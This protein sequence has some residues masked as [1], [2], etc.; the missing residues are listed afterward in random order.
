LDAVDT[1]WQV[2]HGLR[3]AR[4]GIERMLRWRLHAPPTAVAWLRYLAGGWALLYALYRGY[5]ALGG[6]IGMFGT[7]VSQSQ[8]RLINGVAAVLL[9]LA[10]VLPVATARLWQHPR[11]RVVLL[12]LGWVIAVGC[13][14]HALVDITTRLLSIAGVLHMEF[15]FFVA[16]SVDRRASDLQDLFFN[17]PWFLVEGLLWGALCWMELASAR[18]RRWWL[19]SALVATAALTVIG[20]LSAAGIVGR[21]IIG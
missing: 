4:Q 21:F 6:T 9:A 14:M 16:G 3:M 7:P 20:V 17:E 15:P 1:S 5:Y 8:W 10:A 12:A 13:V 2:A 11:G 18:S 19:V